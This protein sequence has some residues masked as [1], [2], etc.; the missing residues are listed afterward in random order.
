MIP[1]FSVS[2]S[3]IVPWPILIGVIAA[4]TVL[5]LWAYRRRLQ[6]DQRPLA[7]GRPVAAAA[8]VLLCLLAALRPSVT[9]AGEEEAGGVAGLPGRRQ[10]A[11]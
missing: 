7:V 3:P 8:G 10:H 11:A 2:V 6:R 9:L 5:T 4:V 1:E